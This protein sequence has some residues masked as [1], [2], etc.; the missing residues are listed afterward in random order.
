MASGVAC[1][2]NKA[3]LVTPESA[4]ETVVVPAEIPRASPPASMVATPA[5]D[6]VHVAWLVTFCVPPSEVGPVAVNGC[7]APVVMVAFDGVTVMDVSV[8]GGRTVKGAA[9]VTPPNVAKMVV[10]PTET[11]VARPLELI[12][13]T[14]DDDEVHVTWLVKFCVL[15]SE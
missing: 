6:E 1:T 3:L 9:P 10:A 13:A 14:P 4:A 7:E 11:P 5:F 15:P 12:V 2:I 8:G